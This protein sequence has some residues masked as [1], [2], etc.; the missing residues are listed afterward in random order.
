MQCKR[1][2]NS[3]HT[4]H[5]HMRATMHRIS[6][7]HIY[8]NKQYSFIH[9]NYTNTSISLYIIGNP[10]ALQQAQIQYARTYRN[11]SST[12]NWISFLS[13]WTAAISLFNA[14]VTTPENIRPLVRRI[15]RHCSSMNLFFNRIFRCVFK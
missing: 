9:N 3:G 4:N 11:S 8:S 6:N 1:A 12:N 14:T 15:R 2:S 13:V 5:H 10:R 7:H